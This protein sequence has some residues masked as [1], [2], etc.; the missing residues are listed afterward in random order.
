MNEEVSDL[1]S[2]SSFSSFLFILPIHPSSFILLPSSFPPEAA[3]PLLYPHS[4]DSDPGGSTDHSMA[5]SVRRQRF[6][7][8]TAR[9]CAGGEKPQRRVAGVSSSKGAP[10]MSL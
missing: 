1:S 3:R 5:R 9:G 2:Y 10:A 7:D 6:S 8:R 4:G